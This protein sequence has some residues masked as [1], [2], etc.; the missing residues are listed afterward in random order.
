MRH[1]EICSKY[2]YVS[3]AA[4]CIVLA[5]NGKNHVRYIISKRKTLP[6]F[7]TSAFL[8]ETETRWIIIFTKL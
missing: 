5:H 8:E 1:E 6:M 2:E 3:Y 7:G 4:D